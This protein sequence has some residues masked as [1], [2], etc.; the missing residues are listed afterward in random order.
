MG[1]ET[2]RG[3][4]AVGHFFQV[5]LSATATACGPQGPPGGG[6]QAFGGEGGL[7]FFRPR[8]LCAAR[9]QGPFPQSLVPVK[10]GTCKNLEEPNCLLV[11][12]MEKLDHT[13]AVEELPVA[14]W[15][16][17]KQISVAART[18]LD[19]TLGRCLQKHESPR[20]W[21]LNTKDKATIAELIE[22]GTAAIEHYKV[23][24]KDR[25]K[26]APLLEQARILYQTWRP[27]LLLQPPTTEDKDL[28]AASRRDRKVATA[29]MRG[30][31][32][33]TLAYAKGPGLK[34]FRIGA[35]RF[36]NCKYSVY[37]WNLLIQVLQDHEGLYPALHN[38][39]INGVWSR[40]IA[41]MA[42][43]EWHWGMG[44]L[45]RAT[46]NMFKTKPKMLHTLVEA[47]LRRKIEYITR[48][49]KL[50]KKMVEES[51]KELAEQK[52][53][54]TSNELCIQLQYSRAEK[55]VDLNR[56]T[57][58]WE[59]AL[60]HKSG[61]YNDYKQ[62]WLRVA[63]GAKMQ[64][65][66]HRTF[67]IVLDAGKKQL[68]ELLKATP[69]EIEALCPGI[70]L[71]EDGDICDAH[72]MKKIDPNSKRLADE[73]DTEGKRKRLRLPI[74]RGKFT[75]KW[76]LQVVEVVP[77]FG[78]IRPRE[79]R[80]WRPAVAREVALARLREEALLKAAGVDKA[81]P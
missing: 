55:T 42:S 74:D 8:P 68:Q 15:E 76:E 56:L 20:S 73:Y 44:R 69:A 41:A 79:I 65:E 48:W 46:D 63:A 78:Q 19:N 25:R 2:L 81:V 61:S 64:Q 72:T 28:L 4:F 16:M 38:L 40:K 52:Q 29:Q 33:W 39:I 17:A 47:V 70:E 31:G 50:V 54:Q 43:A 11:R 66:A 37:Y 3:A 24:E 22:R 14:K 9:R 45:S 12:T 27:N 32:R 36:K 51:E 67:S 18:W 53:K 6:R 57:S 34:H 30:E 75:E 7:A 58:A 77:G 71:D 26:T 80:Q 21:V 5:H 62:S 35:A 13:K 49:Q 23:T 10:S 1:G 59:E 60:W